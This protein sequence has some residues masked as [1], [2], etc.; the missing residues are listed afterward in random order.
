MDGWMYVCMDVWA[1]FLLKF[2]SSHE[3]RSKVLE[4]PLREVKLVV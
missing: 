1:M 4:I 3:R 2:H